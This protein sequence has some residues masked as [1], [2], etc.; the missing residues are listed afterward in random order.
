MEN[1]QQKGLPFGKK[2][3]CG[4]FFV[5]KVSRALNKSEA[6]ALKKELLAKMPKGFKGAQRA[7]L[8]VIRCSDIAG[9]WRIE[10]GISSAMFHVFDN[11]EWVYFNGDYVIKDET[12]KRLLTMLFCDTTVL[13]DKEYVEARVKA[14]NGFIERVKINEIDESEEEKTLEVLKALQTVKEASDGDQ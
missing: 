6:K 11:F 14:M 10:W 3:R 12:C 1:N 8:P 13:G 4:N 9:V 2:L 5:E 7:S